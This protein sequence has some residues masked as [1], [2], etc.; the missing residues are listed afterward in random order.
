MC[1]VRRKSFPPGEE[2]GWGTFL[3]VGCCW[4]VCFLGGGCISIVFE[5]RSKGGFSG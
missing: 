2:R 3:M 1:L 4:L 5:S